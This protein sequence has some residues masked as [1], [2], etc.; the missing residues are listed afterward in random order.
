MSCY[1][2]PSHALAELRKAI[3]NGPTP[4][5]RPRLIWAFDVGKAGA[6]Y[7]RRFV[8]QARAEGWECGAAQPMGEGAGEGTGGGKLNWN[9]FAQRDRLGAD[10]LELYRWHGDVLIAA[11]AADKAH[12][13]W[14]REGW[15]SFPFD[16]ETRTWWASYDAA[17]IAETIAS[18]ADT[19]HVQGLEPEEK[20]DMATREAGL[21]REIANCQFRS[22]Y[23]QREEATDETC[24]YLGVDF[25]SDRAGI[26]GTFSGSSLSAGAEFKKRL[27]SLAPGGIW[28]G[29]TQQL[30]RIMQPASQHPHGRGDPVHRLLGR[31]WRLCVRR[32]RGQEP[33]RAYPQRG[34]LLRVRRPRGQAAL[35]R[36]AA[37]PHRL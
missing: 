22:L 18:Y 8:A 12:L 13:I 19:P 36:E 27:I 21:V 5:L 25:P 9:D 29:S 32:P 20:R 24:Y 28:T 4:A 33:P 17:R 11:T 34:R 6:E 30:D 23:Y 7:T 1:N 37:A 10:R 31:A 14:S 3:A 26:K 15:A 16:F 35:L 2:Y